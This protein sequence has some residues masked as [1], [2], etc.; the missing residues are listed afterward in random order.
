MSVHTENVVASADY[1]T[2]DPFTA[3]FQAD[4]FP[5]YRRLR[6]EAPVYHNTTWEF[7]ALS[8]FDDVRAAL[9]DHENY[10]NFQGVDIDD[11]ELEQ[12]GPGLLPDLDN[13]RH[14]QLRKVVQRSFMPRSIRA[15]TDNVRTVCDRLTPS[16]TT[17]KSI[18]PQ[19][20]RGPYPLRSSSIF[21]D[22][23]R[24]PSERSSSTGRTAS[25]IAKSAHQSSPRLPANPLANCVIISPSFYASDAAILARTC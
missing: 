10:L 17:T 3:E 20:W 2:Y 8:R 21:W 11:F 24:G 4:P 7:Y 23:R 25:S 19:N 5:V 9:R 15:L 22:C 13:P 12:R 1:P 14:D 16:K 6:A 18:W